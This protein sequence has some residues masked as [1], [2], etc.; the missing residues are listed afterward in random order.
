MTQPR[1][2][3][4]LVRLLSETMNLG[5]QVMNCA[6]IAGILCLE[7]WSLRSVVLEGNGG[8]GLSVTE[9]NRN[10]ELKAEV[11]NMTDNSIHGFSPASAVLDA[12]A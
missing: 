11:L 10:S 8:T 4:F 2:P 6:V 9:A 12:A 3:V 5:H 7:L 1:S